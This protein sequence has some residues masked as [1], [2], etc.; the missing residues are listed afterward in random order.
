M[1]ACIR[2]CLLSV[3]TSYLKYRILRPLL[4]PKSCPLR[5]LHHPEKIH[6]RPHQDP[7]R[8]SIIIA[9][10]RKHLQ[11]TVIVPISQ[12]DLM[13]IDKDKSRSLPTLPPQ[14]QRGLLIAGIKIPISQLNLKTGET[15]I[16]VRPDFGCCNILASRYRRYYNS[17]KLC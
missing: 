17:N 11:Q 7:P 8:S 3:T 12:P 2:I 10:L 6:R 13:L 14:S 4:N 16:K 1:T 5:R 15:G 9:T